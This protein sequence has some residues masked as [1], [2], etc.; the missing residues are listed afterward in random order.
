MRT[1]ADK[2]HHAKEE[3]LL[4]PALVAAGFPE[5]TGPVAVLKSEHAQARVCIG[6]LAAA[7]DVYYSDEPSGRAQIIAVVGCIAELYPQ[8]IAKENNVLFPMAEQRLAAG[9]LERL[10][11]QFDAAERALGEE[12]HH[13]WAAV[14]ERLAAPVVAEVTAPAA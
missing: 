4:F 14:A 7:I 10:G 6:N 9:E 3:D 11:N 13:H 1:F 2:C 8:H 12:T 5:T